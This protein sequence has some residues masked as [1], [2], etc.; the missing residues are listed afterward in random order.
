MSIFG[1][2][3]VRIFLHSEWIRIDTEYLS[4]YIYVMQVLRILILIRPKIT[5]TG[6]EVKLVRLR[7]WE[8]ARLSTYCLTY[9]NCL[10]G[11]YGRR[12][13]FFSQ[14][15]GRRPTT[16]LKMS[17]L[18]LNILKNF[19][20]YFFWYFKFWDQ[21]AP[22][23][24][25]FRRNQSIDLSIKMHVLLIYAKSLKNNFERVYFWVKF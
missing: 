16:S 2:I 1:V 23:T 7:D 15:T 5:I 10:R 13:F 25:C 4:L 3:L 18:F 9:N 6:T 11:H 20:S 21:G 17:S 8:I 14:F 12:C 19:L 22:L 24:G